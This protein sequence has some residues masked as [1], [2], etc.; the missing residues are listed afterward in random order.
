MKK[1]RMMCHKS[2]PPLEAARQANQ[3]LLIS[4]PSS[5]PRLTVAHKSIPGSSRAFL[6]HKTLVPSN[7]APFQPSLAERQKREKCD[8][9]RL[10]KRKEKN[11]WILQV[12]HLEEELG[13]RP[14]FHR[15]E[16]IDPPEYQDIQ[17]APKMSATVNGFFNTFNA[18]M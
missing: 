8:T 1:V 16:Q 2:V 14:H 11:L 3:A 18:K 17:S 5:L 7:P 12:S 9:S 15:P 10:R 13:P 4:L 6:S